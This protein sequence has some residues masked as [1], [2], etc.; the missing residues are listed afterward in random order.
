ENLDGV[1]QRPGDRLVNEYG[2]VRLED[3]PGLVKMRPAVD[4]FQENYIDL[5]HESVNGIDDF[6]A[7]LVAQ[8]LG[9]AFDAVATRRDILTAARIR[10]H[11]AHLAKNAART[12]F[13]EQARE[14]NN[15]RGVETDDAR[16]QLLAWFIRGNENG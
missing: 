15:V 7:V 1:G 9:V 16:F 4:A 5:L 11:N 14:G 8:F 2:F 10:G 3:R 13:V 12:R 6:H